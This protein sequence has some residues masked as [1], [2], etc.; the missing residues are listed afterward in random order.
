MFLLARV[1]FVF[2]SQG[3]QTSLVTGQKYD[4]D[5]KDGKKNGK[6]S[7]VQIRKKTAWVGGELGSQRTAIVGP[8]FNVPGV[9]FSG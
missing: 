8:L 3:S 1:L 9:W 4:G 7:L 6:V 2:A 5:W